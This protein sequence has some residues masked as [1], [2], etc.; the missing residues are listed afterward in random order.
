MAAFA[1]GVLASDVYVSNFNALGTTVSSQ[2][3]ADS[4]ERAKA[5]AAVIVDETL[6]LEKVLS[7]YDPNS[8]ISKLGK[9]AGQ[10]IEVSPDTYE[11]LEK[12]VQ[13][14]AHT[15]GAMDPT[16]GTLVKLWKVDK[17]DHQIP[18]Q[19]EI[20]EAK[21]YVDWKQISFKKE[22]GKLYVKLGPNQEITVGAIGKGFIADKVAQKLR[23][24]SCNDVLVSL[25]GNIITLGTNGQDEPWYIGIQEPGLHQ[26][27][28]TARGDYFAAIA[29][30][31]ESLVTSGDYE[32]FFMQDGKKYH[33]ILDPKTGWPVPAT[34]S[35]VTIINKNSA[36]AD[37]MCTALFVMGWDKAKEYLAEHP[38]IKGVLVDEGLGKIAVSDNIYYELSVGDDRFKVERIEPKEMT[39]NGKEVK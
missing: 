10:W 37:G 30:D 15:N 19:A 22:G 35:S 23:D 21:K 34:L 8:D 4:E 27:S 28:G 16:V 25:G 29:S 39:T 18:S 2:I 1:T 12:A 11:I 24:N 20:D 14:S 32:K 38:N 9:N 17:P 6:R 3:K 26:E 5:C 36:Y 7:A 13:I 33:H 31:N